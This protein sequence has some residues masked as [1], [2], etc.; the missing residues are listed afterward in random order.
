MT[1]VNDDFYIGYET[2]LPTGARARIFGVIGVWLAAFVAT[3]LIVLSAQSPLPASSFAYGSSLEFTG[4]VQLDPYPMLHTDDG[5]LWIVGPGKRG[6]RS[7]LMD[8]NG[9]EVRLLGALIQRGPHRMVEL[10]PESLTIVPDAS[11]PPEPAP[12]DY[13]EAELAG[14]IVDAKCY[15]GVM[16]PGA[17]TVHRDCARACLRGE[18]P[19]MFAVTG[20]DGVEHLFL[21]VDRHGGPVSRSIAPIA[22]RPQTIGGRVWREPDSGVW[23]LQLGSGNVSTNRGAG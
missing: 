3:L 2:A 17:G 13:G 9:R 10:I 4:K 7:W 6:A 19:A 22:G 11:R 14:E 1:P 15:L 20:T 16:N 21:L 5:R 18:L 23:I 8:A 12:V